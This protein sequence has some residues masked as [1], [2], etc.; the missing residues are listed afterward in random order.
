MA[1]C[2]LSMAFITL[3]SGIYC[4]FDDIIVEST[5]LG[6]HTKKVKTGIR[7][8]MALFILS[9]FMFFFT[10]FWTF[11]HSSLA[12][13]PQIGSIW[14]PKYIPVLSPLTIPL[15]NT[16]I[17]LTSGSWLTYSHLNLLKGNYGATCLGLILTIYLAGTF[18]LLQFFEYQMAKFHF[19][20]GIYGSIFYMLTGFHGF[21][22]L[23][24]T[25]FL[26]VALSR[27]GM[28]PYH[29]S[30]FTKNNHLGYELSIWYWHFVDLIWLLV[31]ILVYCWGN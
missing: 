2:L 1:K 5:F 6:K 3:C 20:D 18:M 19:N 4:W 23:C 27:L 28:N 13:T 9:E 14:P 22:V 8:G 17:L 7:I 16:L 29:I 30:T 15:I 21:H 31:Y 10:F 24:G 12:P 25:I 26:I 11:L